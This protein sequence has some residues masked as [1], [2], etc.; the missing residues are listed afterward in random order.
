MRAGGVGLGLLAN[1]PLRSIKAICGTTKR[2]MREKP[3][4]LITV[5]R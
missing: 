5:S 3:M 4:K 2:S 1:L